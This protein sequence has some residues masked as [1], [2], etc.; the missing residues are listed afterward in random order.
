MIALIG[1]CRHRTDRASFLPASE[2]TDKNQE[3][4]V[5]NYPWS[6][7]FP[8]GVSKVISNPAHN[9]CCQFA[10]YTAMVVQ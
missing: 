7:S 9:A 2:S 4:T 10:A 6:R 3:T 8:L 1:G 5:I